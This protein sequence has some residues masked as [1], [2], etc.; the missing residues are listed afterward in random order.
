M[1]M[2]F[3]D[4]NDDND[5]DEVALPGLSVAAAKLWCNH[6]GTWLDFFG[7]FSFFFRFDIIGNQSPVT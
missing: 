5:D 7:I 1:I 4:D 6:F 2:M 3:D